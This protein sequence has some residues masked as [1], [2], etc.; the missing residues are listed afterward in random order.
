[1]K[2]SKIVKLAVWFILFIVLL[3]VGFRMV[4]A[5]N[6]IENIIGFFIVIAMVIITIKTKF[7]TTIKLKERKHEK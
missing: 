1:M 2:T 7:L 4:T 6:T 3:N 5:S